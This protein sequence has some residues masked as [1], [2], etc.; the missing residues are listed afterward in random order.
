MDNVRLKLNCEILHIYTRFFNKQLKIWAEAQSWSLLQAHL[1]LTYCLLTNLLGK[2]KFRVC[3][4]KVGWAKPLQVGP[5]PI[6]E[7]FEH[8]VAY[9]NLLIKKAYSY[10]Y[11]EILMQNTANPL[12]VHIRKKSGFYW[13]SSMD[14]AKNTLV[15]CH[16]DADVRKN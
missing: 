7:R 5:L 15:E 9:K 4:L 2:T 16:V 8:Q 10:S 3:L 13:F 6:F 1:L 14:N 12:Q 11:I